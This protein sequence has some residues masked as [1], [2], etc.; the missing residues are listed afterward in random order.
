MSSLIASRPS[1]RRGIGV[2][3]CSVLTKLQVM[4]ESSF[5]ASRPSLSEVSMSDVV[6]SIL[7]ELQVIHGSSLI[8]SHRVIGV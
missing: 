4:H 7:A 6:Y 8:A 1:C 3:V 2:V 5:V